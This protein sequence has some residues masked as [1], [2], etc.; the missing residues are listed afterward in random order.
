[1]IYEDNLLK[2]Q[3]V[4]KTSS[5]ATAKYDDKNIKRHG[6]ESGDIKS[7]MILSQLEVAFVTVYLDH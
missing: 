3:T 7:Q 5:E 1:M 6:I 4:L 2:N